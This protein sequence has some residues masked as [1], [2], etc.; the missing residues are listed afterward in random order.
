ML[1]GP[2]QGLF[3]AR[4][5]GGARGEGGAPPPDPGHPRAGGDLQLQEAAKKE[6]INEIRKSSR[7]AKEREHN[8]K[9]KA[10]EMLRARERKH[11][12]EKI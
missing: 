12:E 7:L 6:A 10:H 8:L 11:E 4:A 2:A 5:D 3:I 9:V 1:R